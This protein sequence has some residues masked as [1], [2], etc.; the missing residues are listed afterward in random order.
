LWEDN[1][2][3]ISPSAIV[4][5]DI[6]LASHANLNGMSLRE[7][8][9]RRYLNKHYLPLGWSCEGIEEFPI[10]LPYNGDLPEYI[11]GTSAKHEGYHPTTAL[12]NFTSDFRNERWWNDVDS[13]IKVAQHYGCS[14]GLDFSALVNGRRCE[15]VEAIRRNRTYTA[16]L[17]ASGLNVIQSATFGHPKHN[18]FVFDGLAPN[19]PVAIEHMRT[20]QDYK[21][22][23]YF[24][25]GVESLVE[26]KNPSIILV[27]GFPLDFDPGVPIKYYD[28][29]I[30]HLRKL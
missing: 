26:Q 6:H 15:V 10:N 8:R 2:Y 14:F 5:P 28:C 22:R 11:V 18:S 7:R 4:V 13:F 30:Q 19:A 25:L 9:K 12:H 23:K 27:V 16:T 20:S 21:Q 1:E 29:F 17:Q 3:T 24:R